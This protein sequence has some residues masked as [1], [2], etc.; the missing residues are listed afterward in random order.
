ME[1]EGLA[2]KTKVRHDAVARGEAG[3]I[4]REGGRF[5]TVAC[6]SESF[7]NVA[8]RWPEAVDVSLLARYARHSP[9]V[10]WR[11]ARRLIRGRARMSAYGPSRTSSRA[12]RMSGVGARADFT[13]RT[14]EVAF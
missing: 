7:H 5:V 6:G 2:V 4:Q 1:K 12:K 3:P 9:T 8:N 10:A 13:R 11:L 14:R